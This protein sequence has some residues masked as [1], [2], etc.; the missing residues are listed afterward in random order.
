MVYKRLVRSDSKEREWEGDVIYVKY[1]QEP[2]LYNF[3]LKW[4]KFKA[5]FHGLLSFAKQNQSKRNELFQMIFK[6][7][8]RRG[9]SLETHNLMFGSVV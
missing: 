9:H 1:R 6:T 2:K 4:V 3:T 5:K 8:I 7:F